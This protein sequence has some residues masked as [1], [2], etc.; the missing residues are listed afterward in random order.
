MAAVLE[1]DTDLT[2][3][4]AEQVRSAAEVRR[5]LRIVGGGTKAFYG[6]PV[7]GAP[8]ELAGHRGIVM[9]DP[10]ELVLIAR[11]G[12][13]LAHIEARL[14]E[15][16]QMLGFE[17][18]LFGSASTLGGAVAAGLAG[19]RR[20]FVGA[21]RDFVLGVKILDGRG[22]ALRFGGQV[23]K[24]VAGFDAF[25]LMAGAL[26]GLGV[27]LEVSLRVTPRPPREAAIVL[28]LAPE[29]A[30]AWLSEALRRPCPV[31]GAYHDGTRLHLRLS[32]GEAGVA[33]ALAQFG[34]Q[35]GPLAFWDDLRQRSHPMFAPD[36]PLWRLSLP[37]TVPP[38]D[39]GDLVAWDWAG[40]QRWVRSDRPAEAIRRAAAEAGGHAT[41]FGAATPAD[42]RFQPLAPAVLAL[43]QRLKAA[44]DPA[45]VLNPGRMYPEL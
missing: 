1:A 39:V 31:S 41:L 44:L 24:N 36:A 32:G 19:Q 9:H 28:D 23:F 43:H 5:P 40:A 29:P 11:A 14:A 34:G 17:P 10:S 3:A 21:V 2:E 7:D 12:T 8:L 20:P 18:P 42:L 6:R 22:Q 38:P 27:I 16:G 45:G 26:G 13:P 25:R 30:R 15:H 37:R 4:L 33:A 35:T